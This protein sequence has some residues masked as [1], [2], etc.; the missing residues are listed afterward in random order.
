M[1]VAHI[2]DKAKKNELYNCSHRPHRSRAS[3]F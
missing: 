3:L 2:I 1:D